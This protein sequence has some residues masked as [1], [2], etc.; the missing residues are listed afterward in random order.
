M[1]K[2]YQQ[3]ETI[4]IIVSTEVA[5]AGAS[6]DPGRYAAGDPTVVDGKKIPTFIGETA[7]GIDP[8]C[9][10]GQGSGGSGNR[11]NRGLWDFEEEI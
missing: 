6:Q 7:E 4:L 9:G 5:L 10:K 2:I 11:S 1:K 3:P 8:F